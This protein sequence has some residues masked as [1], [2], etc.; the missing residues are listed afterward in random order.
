MPF[1]SKLNLKSAIFDKARRNEKFKRLPL[2]SA[3]N[4]RGVLKQKM[5][6]SIPQG[7][8]STR[9]K[10]NSFRATTRRSKRGQRPAIQTRNLLNS[11]YAR[12]TGET[13][14]KTIVTADYAVTLQEDLGRKVMTDNDR[15]EAEKEFQQRAQ[16]VVRELL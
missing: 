13:S 8:V 16:K 9:A 10:G 1:K 6:D 12:R 15:K 14:A 11:I 7:K 5:I 4:F 3:Q 2:D